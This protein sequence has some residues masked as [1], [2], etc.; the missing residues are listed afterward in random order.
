MSKKLEREQKKQIN[1]KLQMKFSSTYDCIG[2]GILSFKNLCPIPLFSN[3]KICSNQKRNRQS[4]N[5]LLKPGFQ[6]VDFI[7]LYYMYPEKEWKLD[8]R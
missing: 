1:C 4:S 7:S 6:Y 2:E 8:E 3:N 5:Q